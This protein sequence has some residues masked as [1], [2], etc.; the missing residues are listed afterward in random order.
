MSE[1]RW[2]IIDDAHDPRLD[3]YHHLTDADARRSL[4]SDHGIFVAEGTG[5]IRRL[6]GSTYPVRSLLLLPSRAEEL[7][8]DLE[9]CAAPAFVAERSVLAEVTGFDVHRG[10]LAIADRRALTEPSALITGARAIVILEGVNDHE[11]LGAVV[12]SASALGVDAILLD[13]TCAD[14]LY[15]RA[16]RV[17]MGEVLFLPW[18][19][20]T[21][22]PSGLARVRAAGFALIALTPAHDAEPLERVLDGVEGPV[23][24]LLG[25]EGPGLS[26]AAQ[27]AADHRARIPIRPGVDS[28]NVGHAAAIAFHSVARR[29]P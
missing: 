13:P 26:A 15:R 29:R 22:W 21:P 17:S 20:L 8:P 2:T 9:V 5:V 1:D 10:A 23:A 11:N 12:R 28:L 19:R 3:L 25:A 4:E 6:L 16:V 24:L 14:P 27:L 7:A 18:T